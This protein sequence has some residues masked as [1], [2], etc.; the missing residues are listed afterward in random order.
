M[1]PL[2]WAV[3]LFLLALLW[4]QR[5]PAVA[6]GVF[7]TA[8]F[9]TVFLGWL[10]PSQVALRWIE[11]QYQVPTSSLQPY[12]G[13]VVLGGQIDIPRDPKD[14]RPFVLTNGGLRMTASVD[15]SRQY[16]NLQLLFSGGQSNIIDREISVADAA[17]A[18]YASMGVPPERLL[19]ER[20]ART[21]YENAVLS[22]A[23]PGVD[24]TRPWLLLTSAWHMPRSMALF[25]GAGWNV[26]AYPVDF[27]A[28][29]AISWTEYSLYRGAMLWQVVLHE[30]G[31][32]MVYAMMGRAG[33]F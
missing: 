10:A 30:L 16:P 4:S 27:R 13:V 17:R 12:V 15:L 14:K 20:A 9:F 33:S 8:T 23:V 28:P 5:R 25:R 24:K 6:R 21:T 29:A 3:L 11:D 32:L 19:Y 18:Y 2:T 26:T 7:A 31:G 1:Q 22:A